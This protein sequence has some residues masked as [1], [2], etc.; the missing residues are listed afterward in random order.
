VLLPILL[1]HLLQL[2]IS[3]WLTPVLARGYTPDDTAA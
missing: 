2:M 1:Y 3:A